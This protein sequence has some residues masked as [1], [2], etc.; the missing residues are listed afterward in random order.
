[1][2]PRRTYTPVFLKAIEFIL[3]HEEQFARGHW[4]DENYVVTENVSGDSGGL[5]K[6]GIDSKS[7]PGVDVANLTR[8]G[9]IAIYWQEWNWRNV[10]L[11]P[12][13][14]AIALFDVWVNG[15]YPVRWLQCAINLANV[16]TRAPHL[17]IDGD[18]GPKTVA[19]AFAC[20]QA[21]VLRY[22]IAER[23]ARFARLAV[24]PRAKFLHGWQDRDRDL[25][26][27]LNDPARW[28]A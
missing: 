5:T 7:H 11:L 15:G 16:L 4:G 10:D 23:E 14:L 2:D 6:Y 19:A 8:D 1:M 13:K 20:D 18:L 24:G 26:A 27:F 22:F 3:P 25:T 9:A 21:A 17:T 28:A 12:E